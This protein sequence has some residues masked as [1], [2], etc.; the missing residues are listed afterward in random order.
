MTRFF[1]R[2]LFITICLLFFA[3]INFAQNSTGGQLLSDKFM[4]RAQVVG[5]VLLL[6]LMVFAVGNDI[7]KMFE[8]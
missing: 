1:K 5:M 7:L 2:V 8:K 6:S 4:E 3:K